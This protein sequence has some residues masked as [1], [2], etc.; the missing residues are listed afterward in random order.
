MD[1]KIEKGIPLPVSQRCK[2]AATISD[3]EI[4]DSILLSLKDAVTF[5][6]A[7]YRINPGFNITRRKQPDG[8]TRIW[9]IK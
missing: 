6:G 9:A 5:A 1:Y 3:M 2:W 7:V 8:N 4:G